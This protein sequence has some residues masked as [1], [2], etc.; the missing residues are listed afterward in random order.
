MA[1]RLDLVRTAVSKG[2]RTRGQEFDL[3]IRGGQVVDGTGR[4]GFPT[5]IGVVEGGIAALGSLSS[6][7][8]SHVIDAN[9]LI[10]APGIIDMHT[11]SDLSLLADG[12]AESSVAQGV[13]TEVVGQ[14]GFSAA[15][16]RDRGAFM[17]LSP[18]LRQVEPR[19]QDM[20]GYLGTLESVPLTHNVLTL[21]G[22]STVRYS[23]LGQLNGPP[24]KGELGRMEDEVR[25][26]LEAGA[27][28]LSSG[29]EY[30]PGSAASAEEL[31]ALCRVVREYSGLYASHI[32]SM[33]DDALTATQELVDVCRRTGVRAH[34]SHLGAFF[35]GEDLLPQMI[36]AMEDARSNGLQITADATLIGIV[37]SYPPERQRP[38]G[39]TMLD[40]ILPPWALDGGPRQEL[41]R[42]RDSTTRERLK[43]YDRP[44]FHQV[45]TGAWEE[46]YLHSSRANPSEV[47]L[48]IAEIAALRGRSGHD[49]ALDL[50]AEEIEAGETMAPMVTARTTPLA[51]VDLAVLWEHS[52]IISDSFSVSR[53]GPTADFQT[54]P[55]AYGNFPYRY[56]TQMQS[57]S[58]EEAIRKCTS[59]PARVLGLVDRGEIRVGMKADLMIFHP[60]D[61]ADKATYE[62]PR[63]L[64]VGIR[65]VIVNGEPVVSEGALTGRSPGE[66]I[67]R[68][69]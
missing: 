3:V 68:G 33:S 7:S 9:D 5:D 17:F 24:G 36:A 52:C 61:V 57:L 10:V 66:V 13:T 56:V 42:L 4:P 31:V 50:L 53:D 6:A 38:S 19:W 26:A 69:R 59:L 27:F 12:R 18:W 48:S 60:R 55:N 45:L 39:W 29:L 35:P 16:A 8:A 43:T 58:L 22:H 64:P 34:H 1:K 67:R 28:G 47:G 51:N 62:N 2:T 44:K 20:D 11:H 14:C 15:P 54:V 32:R 41:L 49:V 37:S 21:V 46:I 65:H 63:S 40:T 23:V 25:A 30:F